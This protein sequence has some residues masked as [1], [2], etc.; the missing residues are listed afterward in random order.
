MIRLSRLV[1]RW[2]NKVFRVGVKAAGVHWETGASTDAHPS[3]S[4]HEEEDDGN[5]KAKRTSA[6]KG[7]ERE[8]IAVDETPA[9]QTG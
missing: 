9:K 2:W 7:K 8:V 6:A 3:V 1:H 4:E 5:G